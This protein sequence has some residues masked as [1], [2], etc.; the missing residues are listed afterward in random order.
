MPVPHEHPALHVDLEN[1]VH[2]LVEHAR[3][4]RGGRSVQVAVNLG[5]LEKGARV[6]TAL[7][8]VARDEEVIDAVP[9][10]PP[11]R[12]RRDG[13]RGDEPRGAL[14]NAIDDGRL[15]R[16]GRARDDDE[17]RSARDRYRGHGVSHS[18]F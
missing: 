6:A 14:E 4:E 8:F 1:D 7:E 11:R 12:A 10:L 13:H 16:P 15:A 17:E 9:L 2:S 3:H 5:P 18:R